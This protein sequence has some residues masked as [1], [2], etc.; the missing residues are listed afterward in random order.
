MFEPET[1]WLVEAGFTRRNTREAILDFLRKGIWPQ[2]RILHLTSGTYRLQMGFLAITDRRVV[3]GMYWAFFPFIKKRF[4]VPHEQISWARMDSKPW[5]ARLILDS[6]MG[7]GALGNLEE[8]E[9]SRLAGLINA[10][11]ARGK[12]AV[13]LAQPSSGNGGPAPGGP[14]ENP[15]PRADSSPSGSLPSRPT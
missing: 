9:A 5:G 2:E 13:A 14:P 1:A 8:D 7:R 10:L 6:T 4:A 11:A 12:R 15:G 3:F